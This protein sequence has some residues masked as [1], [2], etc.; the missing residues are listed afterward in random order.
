MSRVNFHGYLHSAI[1]YWPLFR[2]PKF[3]TGPYFAGPYFAKAEFGFRQLGPLFSFLY[4]KSSILFQKKTII[5]Y[6]QDILVNNNNT[7]HAMNGVFRRKFRPLFS[8]P[9]FRRPLFRQR[10]KNFAIRAGEVRANKVVH[11]KHLLY[12]QKLLRP[13]Y[14][15]SHINSGENFP[16]GNQHG[17]KLSGVHLAIWLN[18]KK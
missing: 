15:S 9:L 6:T 5:S 3:F 1:P 17:G 16:V 10:P 2:R 18:L 4:E 13:M 8:R 14:P 11:I 12:T 7:T